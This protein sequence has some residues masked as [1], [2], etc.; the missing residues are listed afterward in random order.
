MNIQPPR[1]VVFFTLTPGLSPDEQKQTLQNIR[2]SIREV[3]CVQ[4]CPGD[5]YEAVLYD[6]ARTAVA[7][8]LTISA[9][10]G[11][12]SVTIMPASSVVLSY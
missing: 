2:L 10:D 5:K 9:H 3:F 6:P 12:R 8:A 4:A 11:V 7:T 1:D